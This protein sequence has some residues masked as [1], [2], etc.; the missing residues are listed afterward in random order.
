MALFSALKVGDVELDHRV[1]M[2]AMTRLRNDPVSEAPR[3]LNALYYA[4]RASKGGLLISEGTHPSAIG[5]GYIRAPG[6]WTNEH[7]EGWKQVTQAVHDKG[8]FIFC[9]LMHTGRVS[10][11]SLLPDNALPIAPS[12]V[13]MEGLVHVADGKVP[14]V[15]PRAIETEEMPDVVNSLTEAA[16]N[17]MAAGFDGVELHGGNG[18]LIQEF[19]AEQTNRRTDNYGGSVQNRCRFLLEAVDACVSAI[20][21]EHV[22]VKLQC[23]ISFSDLIETEEDSKE[24]L[25]YLGPE[26]DKRQLAYVCMS[27]LNYEPYYKF[28]G[29]SE[30]NFKSDIWKFFRDQYKGVL[31]INGGLTPAKA[32]EYVKDGTADCVAFGTAFLASANL[33]HL[34]K[35]GKEVNMGGADTSTWYGKDP[36]TD[37][38]NYTDWPLVE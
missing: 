32:E 8:G 27:S 20:G 25:R 2:S 17:A 26:L 29:L 4:Q 18:Y 34:L 37:A 1:V 13:K 19:L 36:A 9:Q 3:E 24:Q 30:P 22:G 7:I 6:I 38:V 16:K 15:T 31:M 23:G 5:R 11:P 35:S 12:A 10:H 33:A 14:Y 28:V 21:K